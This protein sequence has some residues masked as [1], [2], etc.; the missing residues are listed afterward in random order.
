MEKLELSKKYTSC[1]KTGKKELCVPRKLGTQSLFLPVLWQ[2]IYLSAC[3]APFLPHI[4][5]GKK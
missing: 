2:E 5:E 1:H 3:L 4:G